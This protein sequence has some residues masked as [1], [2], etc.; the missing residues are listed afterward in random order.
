LPLSVSG[1]VS[2]IA[3]IQNVSADI[4]LLWAR[5]PVNRAGDEMATTGEKTPPSLGRGQRCGV[6]SEFRTPKVGFRRFGGV[7]GTASHA[8]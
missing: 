2:R 4:S 8:S 5:V 3:L 1:V 7:V 6:A